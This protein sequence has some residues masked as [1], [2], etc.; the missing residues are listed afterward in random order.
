[1]SLIEAR[2][3]VEAEYRDIDT[4]TVD[5]VSAIALDEASPQEEVELVCFIKRSHLYSSEI[6]AFFPKNSIILTIKIF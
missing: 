1:M 5:V 6:F 3:L 4:E 2:P